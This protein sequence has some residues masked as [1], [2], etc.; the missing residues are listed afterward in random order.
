MV[1]KNKMECSGS[2]KDNTIRAVVLWPN[3]TS[4]ALNAAIAANA[5]ESNTDEQTPDFKDIPK[6]GDQ[7]QHVASLLGLELAWKP[8]AKREW[9][10]KINQMK[11]MLFGGVLGIVSVEQYPMDLNLSLIP[12]NTAFF[13]LMKD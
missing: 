4:H 12:N 2:T 3:T 6:D 7:I 11:F 8:T 13:V 9:T 1:K 5:T 10:E